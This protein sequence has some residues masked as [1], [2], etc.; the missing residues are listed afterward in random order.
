MLCYMCKYT[1]LPWCHILIVKG[2]AITPRHFPITLD[3]GS[4]LGGGGSFKKKMLW[5]YFYGINVMSIVRLLKYIYFCFHQAIMERLSMSHPRSHVMITGGA[6]L[7]SLT[8]EIEAGEVAIVK[9]LAS[10]Y[11]RAFDECTKWKVWNFLALSTFPFLHLFA[12]S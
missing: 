11:R 8:A 10:C 12:W 3:W 4:W 7:T 2:E 5:H 9:Y 1:M 6:R